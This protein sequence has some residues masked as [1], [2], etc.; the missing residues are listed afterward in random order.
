MKK[1]STTGTRRLV[2]DVWH[3]E[4]GL[5]PGTPADWDPPMTA[6]EIHLAALSDPD[7]QP[8]SSGDLDRL[9]PVSLAKFVRRKLGLSQPDFANRYHIPLETLRGWEQ[10]LVEPDAAALALLR[11]IE[12]EPERTARALESA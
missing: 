1:I 4:N 3:D 2:G 10:G 7:A 11:V 6:D 5:I 9:H 12:K 8:L